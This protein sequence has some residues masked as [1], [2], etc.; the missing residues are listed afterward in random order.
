M[1]AVLGSCQGAAGPAGFPLWLLWVV[2]GAQGRAWV[3][4]LLLEQGAR[5]CGAVSWRAG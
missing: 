3:A 2:T 4:G 1:T 5:G